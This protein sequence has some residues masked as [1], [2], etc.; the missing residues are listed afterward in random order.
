MA[1]IERSP[2]PA[3]RRLFASLSMECQERSSLSTEEKQAARALWNKEYPAKLAHPTLNSFDQYLVKLSNPMH[4]LFK[5]QNHQL[6][7]W[8]FD[9]NRAEERWFALLVTES[10]QGQG[11][12]REILKQA[13]S[14]E[15]F[16]NGWVIDH[17]QARKI[18]G[19]P[20]RSPL[21]FYLK[22]GFVLNSESRLE[23]DQISAVKITWQDPFRFRDTSH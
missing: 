8:Y 11:W 22:N 6:K 19:E 15:P 1:K 23:T 9:F 20:Y 12:G 10:V 5:D 4:W 16:L 18:N 3:L 7:A 17:S 14:K 2:L 21:G 13:K